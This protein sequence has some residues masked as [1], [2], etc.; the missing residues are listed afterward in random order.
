MILLYCLITSFPVIIIVFPLFSWP[1][2]HT[3]TLVTSAAATGHKSGSYVVD[4]YTNRSSMS[5]STSGQP[6][7]TAGEFTIDALPPPLP[8]D[9]ITPKAGGQIRTH[10]LHGCRG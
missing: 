5:L 2:F 8:P 4:G 1:P 10:Y 9:M 7:S 3:Q 6:T